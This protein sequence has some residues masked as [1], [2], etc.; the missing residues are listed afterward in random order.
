MCLLHEW[1]KKRTEV[2][3]KN[4]Y[5]LED[6][7]DTPERNGENLSLKAVVWLPWIRS[8]DKMQLFRAN[9][10]PLSGSGSWTWFCLRTIACGPPV[11]V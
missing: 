8:R 1:A 10:R 7:R 2:T 9:S 6:L 11:F 5:C 4:G 3:S